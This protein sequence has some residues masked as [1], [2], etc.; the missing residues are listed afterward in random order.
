[1]RAYLILLLAIFSAGAAT[2]AA[3]T[4]TP[5]K[6]AYAYSEDGA[7]IAYYRGRKSSGPPI[8][9]LSGGPGT[10]HR[11][12]R[13]GGALDRLAERRAVIFFDQRGTSNSGVGP[14]PTTIQ[15]LVEDVEAIRLAADAEKVDL[16]GH[17][18]G[19]Y[20]AMA[21][22]ATHPQRVRSMILVASAMPKLG[23]ETQ[24]LEAIYPDKIEQWRKER[25]LLPSVFPAP[26]IKTFQSMEFV[27]QKALKSFLK[28]VEGYTYNLAANSALR[29]D[30]AARDF[31]PQVREIKAPVLVVH[32][33]FDA[34]LAA[35][36][37][38]KLHKAIAGSEFEIVEAAG[39]LPH[40]ERP[41]EFMSRIF[42][43]LGKVDGFRSRKPPDR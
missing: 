31:W 24:L 32:G 34:V 28:A 18:F 36:D 10:D 21:Y 38:W 15:K 8:I 43:F 42:K 41:R 9:V 17:S 19:G 30:M 5:M 37:S 11:Y 33:R 14:A 23:E 26:A 20:L 40:V 13:V 25:S 3:R 27:D 16:L 6:P 29:A 39:H 4:P 12:M 1:M 7:K 35:S 22:A 2:A